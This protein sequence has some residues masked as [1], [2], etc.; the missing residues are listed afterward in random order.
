M[1][2][3]VVDNNEATT[4][5][6]CMCKCPDLD[7]MN[8]VISILRDGKS[9]VA[10]GL[11]AE[12]IKSR[13]R[14]FV[15]L[16]YTIIKRRLAKLGSPTSRVEGWTEKGNRR[17]FGDYHEISFLF[18]PGKVFARID[19]LKYRRDPLNKIFHSKYLSISPQMTLSMM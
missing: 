19:L 8:K 3:H 7:E 16:L 10:D 11:H 15:K 14:R 4:T 18:I 9:P 17:D 13:G 5:Q 6:Q 1:E 12:D 2:Q